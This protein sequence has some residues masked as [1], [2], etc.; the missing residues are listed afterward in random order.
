MRSKYGEFAIFEEL[1][2]EQNLLLGS[3]A[4]WIKY[5]ELRDLEE[6]ERNSRSDIITEQ[7]E[8]FLRMKE[9]WLAFFIL[10]IGALV[11]V[12]IM[13]IFLRSRIR[14]AIALINE[15]SK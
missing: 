6:P 15:G 11:I 2:R 12:L 3:Y 9:A 4:T 13:L 1:F 5:A 7:W 8:S 14:L 10:S